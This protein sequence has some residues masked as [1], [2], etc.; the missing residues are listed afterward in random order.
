M[1]PGITSNIA[2]DF[3]SILVKVYHVYPNVL[4]NLSFVFNLFVETYVTKPN[5]PF[6]LRCDHHKWNSDWERFRSSFITESQIKKVIRERNG[7]GNPDVREQV[8]SELTR[9]WNDIFEN[10]HLLGSLGERV[11]DTASY[12]SNVFEKGILSFFIYDPNFATSSTL[13]SF[14]DNVACR[15]DLFEI[16]PNLTGNLGVII[17]TGARAISLKTFNEL[18]LPV[19]EG[20]VIAP[21]PLSTSVVTQFHSIERIET[22]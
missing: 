7:F 11:T 22:K 20:P 5:S 1:F 13:L 15:R 10:M 21:Q 19:V 6:S 3:S 12:H 9:K 4:S 17:D 2:R 8:K 14:F 18:I 16:V